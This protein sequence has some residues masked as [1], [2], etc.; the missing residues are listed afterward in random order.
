MELEGLAP[1]LHKLFYL[2]HL[3]TVAAGLAYKITRICSVP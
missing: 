3:S 2:K 1:T